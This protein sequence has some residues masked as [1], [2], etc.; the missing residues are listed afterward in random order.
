MASGSARSNRLWRKRERNSPI[1]VQVLLFVVLGFKIFLLL[2]LGFGSL[3]RHPDLRK[4]EVPV[5]KR[6][7]NERFATGTRQH[8]SEY[9]LF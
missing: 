1:I 2:L 3:F 7:F 5:K 4:K 9:S 8:R 6:D